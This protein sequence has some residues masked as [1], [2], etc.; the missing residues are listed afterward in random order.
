MKI[1]ILSCNTG[2]GHN[3]AGYAVKE[4]LE[5]RGVLCEMADAL[6]FAKGDYTS[7]LISGGYVKIVS[8]APL[9]FGGIYKT[10]DIISSAKYHSPVYLANA[11]S[12]K[13]LGRF[14]DTGGYHG[15]VMP[16]VFPAETLTLLKKRGREQLRT[17]AVAT[18]YTCSPFWE[19][20]CPDYFFIPHADLE[21]EFHSKGIPMGKLV[22]TGIPVSKKYKVK[23]SRDEARDRLGLPREATVF[24]IMTGSMGFG[25]ISDVT[26]EI[27]RLTEGRCVRVMVMTGRSEKLKRRLA[28]DFRGDE[29][30]ISIPYT[31]EVP[32]YMDACNVLLTKPGGLTT[33]EAAV[34]QVPFVHTKPIP[35]C[36]TKNAR[37]FAERGMSR[38]VKN[39]SAAPA[40]AVSLAIN[41][42]ATE[43]MI[44]RQRRLMPRDAA[45]AIAGFIIE[46]VNAHRRSK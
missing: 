25:N 19:E 46:D 38:Y 40:E 14:I 4:A 21:E 28:E 16:H 33:T 22:P 42:A 27:L 37:F 35:G 9:V 31:T 11:L 24:L 2:Q 12:A 36:E 39:F 1:L 43:D 30:V 6:S 5:D 45:D 34:K 23:L 15:I 32:L 10:S 13:R 3:S 29:R 44:E 8:K 41:E 7:E 20:T 26:A 17:Y 18:D